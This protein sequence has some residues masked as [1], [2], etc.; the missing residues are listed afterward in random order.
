MVEKN[1]ETRTITDRDYKQA[2]SKRFGNRVRSLMDEKGLSQAEL[3]RRS[4]TSRSVINTLIK[5]ERNPSLLTALTI[6][7]A[8]GSSLDQLVS[9]NLLDLTDNQD[10]VNK[11]FKIDFLQQLAKL[12]TSADYYSNQ[13]KVLTEKDKD[14]ILRLVHAYLNVSES[15]T[16]RGDDER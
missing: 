15:G 2:L 6:S 5:G 10:T 14:T 11:T 1:K 8:L 13:L 4:G 16:Y 9:G 3:A 7:R 12:L